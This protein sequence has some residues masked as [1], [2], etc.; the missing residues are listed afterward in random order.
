MV[1]GRWC[2]A[3]PFQPEAFK[4]MPDVVESVRL[5]AR[6]FEP[7]RVRVVFLCLLA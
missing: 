2:F 1:P 3:G 5:F 6:A 7:E 4:R